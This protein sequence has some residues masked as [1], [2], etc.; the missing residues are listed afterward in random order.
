[1]KN[2]CASHSQECNA[3]ENETDLAQTH[4]LWDSCWMF[5]DILPWVYFNCSEN[6]RTLLTRVCEHLWTFQMAAPPP[7]RRRKSF[8]F[9]IIMWKK[10]ANSNKSSNVSEW[11]QK[12]LSSPYT[13][14]LNTWKEMRWVRYLCCANNKINVTWSVFTMAMYHRII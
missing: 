7:I 5:V 6:L 10:K 14:W 12:R 11:M 9:Y 13:I 3:Q 4:T 2:S 8:A 1:M